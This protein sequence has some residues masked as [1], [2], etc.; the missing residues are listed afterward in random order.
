MNKSFLRSFNGIEGDSNGN[1]ELVISSG[2]LKI[3]EGNGF[4]YILTDRNPLVYGNVGMDAVDFSWSDTVGDTFGAVGTSSFAVGNYVRAG[5]YSSIVFGNDIINNGIGS[6]DAGINLRDAGY[7]NSLFGIGHDVTSMNTTVVGQASNIILEGIIDFNSTNKPLFV[8]GNGTIANNDSDYNVLTRSDALIVR[9]NGSIEAPSLTT[10][11]INED[12]T[13]KI[14]TT[15]EW[16]Q[17]NV[18]TL[19]NVIDAGGAQS[20]ADFGSGNAY[21]GVESGDAANTKFDVSIYSEDS[22]SETQLTLNSGYVIIVGKG[23]NILNPFSTENISQ[24]RIDNGVLGIST[25]L[26]LFSSTIGITTPVVANTTINFPAPNTTGAYILAT[27]VNGIQA[28]VNG[29][30][31][32]SGTQN[33]QSVTYL[34]LTT[35]IANNGLVKGDTYL[36]NDYMTVYTQPQTGVLKSS[37]IIEPLYL[38]ALDIN[39]ISNISYSKL[40][41]Q[42]IIYYEVTGD[43]GNGYGSEGFTKGKI[44]RRIDTKQNNDIGTDWRHV[45]YDRSGTDFLLFEDYNNVYNNFIKTYQLFNTV[46]GNSC[47]DNLIGN[48][49]QDNTIGNGFYSNT[50]GDFFALNTISDDFRRNHIKHNFTSNTIDNNFQSNSVGGGFSYNNIG[51]F[52][53]YNNIG[54]LFQYNDLSILSSIS[55][56]R[57]TVA[58]L[59]TGTKEFG[60]TLYVTDANAPTYLGTLTGGGTVKCPVFWNGTNWIS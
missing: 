12:V 37:E 5:N 19:Q 59:P 53:N 26:G 33:L 48:D 30:V 51:F 10:A 18:P 31:T 14:L 56:N 36:L 57:F 29:N 60:Q 9:L 44:Y 6:F 27:S 52:F 24:I 43:I 17:A 54:N 46:I 38:T 35:L 13:G 28:D 2:L 39:K 7:T 23:S 8:V 4:G 32:L 22:S 50:V 45:K 42:D 47:H 1:I 25:Q 40:Y 55:F 49:F 3:D 21:F 41:P 58:T 20:Y 16:F 34:E 11:L 15:K